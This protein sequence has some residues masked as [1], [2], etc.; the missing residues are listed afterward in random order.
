MDIVRRKLIV[1]ILRTKRLVWC[2]GWVK[3]GIGLMVTK[4]ENLIKDQSISPLV[5]IL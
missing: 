5:I 4:T 2:S 3:S 1:V